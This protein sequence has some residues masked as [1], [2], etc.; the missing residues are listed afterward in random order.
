MTDDP[1]DRL[2]QTDDAALD[3]RWQRLQAWLQERFGRETGIEATLFLIGIQSRGRGYEPK[4]Q[5]EVKQDLIME[6]TYCAFEKLGLY[7][8]IGIDEEGRWIWERVVPH[9]P[10][11]SIEEQEKLLRLGI[12]AYFDEATGT[13]AQG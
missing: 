2:L 5:K 7:E 3:A 12:L 10:K 6:G 11:L 4:L 13:S 1:I 8:R 9:I